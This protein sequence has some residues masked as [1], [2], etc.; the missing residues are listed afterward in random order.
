MYVYRNIETH[1]CNNCWGRKA[2]SITYSEYVF[3]TLGTQLAINLCHIVICSLPGSVKFSILFHHIFEKE[4]YLNIQYSFGSDFILKFVWNISH[5]E[6]N[7]ARNGHNVYRSSSKVPLILSDFNVTWYFL[8]DFRKISKHP[9]SC[10][11]FQWEP[12]CSMW[13]D[14]R[15]RQN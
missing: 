10:K 12:R 15:T 11:S 4:K 9:M 7:W 1:L 3:V 5:F 8:T 14:G 13:T 6:K 2:I